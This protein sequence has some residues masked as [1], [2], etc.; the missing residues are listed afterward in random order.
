MAFMTLGTTSS[1]IRFSVSMAEAVES[2]SE[3][4]PGLYGAEV[5]CVIHQVIAITMA[6]S[7]I[8]AN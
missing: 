1:L 8:A 5:V 2:L 6:I 4:F 3:E 7:F